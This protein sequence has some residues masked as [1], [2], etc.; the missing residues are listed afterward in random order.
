MERV[1]LVLALLAGLHLVLSFLRWVVQIFQ[2]WLLQKPGP[3]VTPEPV[4]ENTTDWQPYHRPA[5][6]RRSR[7]DPGPAKKGDASFEVIA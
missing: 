2:D 3:T 4:Q 6:Q 1:I 7:T 5:C